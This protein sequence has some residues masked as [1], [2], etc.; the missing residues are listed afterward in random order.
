MKKLVIGL[1]IF[2]LTTQVFSQVIELSEVNVSV[3]YKYLD[4]IN[5]DQVA[6]PV[7]T[8][9]EQVLNYDATKGDL[10]DDDFNTYR[11]SFYI[12]DGKVVA[13]YDKNGKILRTIEKYKNIR[14]P[15]QVLQTVAEKYPKWAIVEDVYEV[16]FHCEKGIVKKQYKIKLQNENKTVNIKTDVLGNI[17]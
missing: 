13:A 1:F 17:I 7:K 9:T 14:L 11:V 12:P 6:V 10:Y 15:Q 4:A 2:G 8:L 16:N 5:C 3:N